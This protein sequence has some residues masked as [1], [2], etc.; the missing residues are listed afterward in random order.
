MPVMPPTLKGQDGCT[1]G[2]GGLIG[3]DAAMAGVVK[4]KANIMGSAMSPPHAG[5]GSVD[6]SG[7]EV[8]LTTLH[9]CVGLTAE[10]VV[11]HLEDIGVS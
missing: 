9:R 7:D 8:D 11:H 5:P 1:R 3:A 6:H 4:P 10:G 2:A